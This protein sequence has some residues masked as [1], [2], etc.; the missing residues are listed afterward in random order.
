MSFIW[1][2]MLLTALA[3]PACLIWY[4]LVHRRRQRDAGHL[5]ELG[6]VRDADAR[7]VGWR[8][9]VPP[10]FY[11]LAL[12]VTVLALARPEISLPVPHREGVVILVFDVSASMAAEDLSPTRIAV[13]QSAARGFVDQRPGSTK[14]GVVAFSGSGLVVQEPTDDR[15][16]VT[17]AIDRLIPQSGT[18]LGQGIWAA[19]DVL[20][21]DLDAHPDSG[22]GTQQSLSTSAFGPDAFAPFVIALFTDGE[23]TE[24]PEPLEAAQDAIELGVRIFPIGVGS[25]VGTIVE[26]DGFNLH[27]RLDEDM[28]REIALLTEG[29]YFNADSPEGLQ[30]IYEGLDT[31]F[32][33][34]DEEL[35]LTPILMGVSMVLLLVGG[36]VSA[37]WFGR[38]P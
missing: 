32:V 22:D 24:P 11:L 36:I 6:I 12:L 33:V 17:L 34:S 31:P 4:W 7:P 1:P 16:A 29:E 10:A 37:I 35:E 19:L 14:I 8:R 23:N 38:I 15:L 9:H 21:S 25:E 3:V 13:A 30:T 2:W 26:V 20:T 5:G 18:S 28:L 27:T